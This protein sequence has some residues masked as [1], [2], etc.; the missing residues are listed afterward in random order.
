MSD[1]KLWQGAFDGADSE[2][3]KFNSSENI[4]LDKV[5]AKYDVY[6]SIAHIQMLD[7]QK[8]LTKK[9]A[10]SIIGAL[11]Q[12]L[13]KITKNEFELIGDLEDIHSNVEVIASSISPESKKMHTARSRN[14]QILLD[15]RLF[16]RD[17]VLKIALDSIALQKSYCKLSKE[18][19]MMIGYTHTRV[20]QP[21]TISF[22]CDAQVQSINRDIDRLLE[23]YKRINVNPLGSGAVAGSSWNIDRNYSA[24]L[25]GFEKIEENELDAI[26][27]RGEIEAEILSDLAILMSKLSGVSEELIW[28]SQKGLITIADKFCTGSSM[29][30][31]KKNPD[32]LEL[33]RA[34]SARVHANLL[35]VLGVKK[36]LISG[37]HSD[38][39]E[40]K[41]AVMRGVKT[42]KECLKM[43]GRIIEE[44]KFDQKA[45]EAELKEGYSQ[46]TEIA[47][48]LAKKGITFRE[49][50]AVVGKL[51][52]EC[53]EKGITLDK[54]TRITQLT[55][56][57]W[58]DAL[59]LDRKR[60][61]KEIKIEEEREKWVKI[62]M[63]KIE[64]IYLK[65]SQ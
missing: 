16:L 49:A 38:M 47:D 29:M 46:A 63:E 12:I 2:V 52:N 54:A 19:G 18:E 20:A 26:S 22:W 24:K 21:I 40:T 64:K 31:N 11:K 10:D 62:E 50:H 55:Q 23:V 15:M 17:E 53:R 32:V 13:S 48:A 59:S 33:I 14:D 28:L 9:E 44:L 45:I 30:P 57:E 56:K 58:N 35:H 36:G 8:I 43:L 3:V 25:L 51:V 60:L 27:S 1:K 65:L 4:E 39:Q 5:L 41:Y 7:K 42:T 34:R 61:K 37:Y 6:G